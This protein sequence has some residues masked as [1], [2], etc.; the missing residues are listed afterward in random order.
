MSG[1][2]QHHGYLLS[3]RTGYSHRYLA[4]RLQWKYLLDSGNFG[5]PH[6]EAWQVRDL[7]ALARMWRL[8]VLTTVR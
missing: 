6:S 4:I 8:D 3:T 5:H 1:E 2:F 7:I